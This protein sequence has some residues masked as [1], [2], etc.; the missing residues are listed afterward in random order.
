MKLKRIACLA[1]AVMMM[2]AMAISASAATLNV[3]TD[4]L[5]SS[6]GSTDFGAAYA[7]NVKIV[8]T[9]STV[10]LTVNDDC[11]LDR[12]GAKFDLNNGVAAG[13]KMPY[14]TY[15]VS[16]DDANCID[17]LALALYGHTNQFG[18]G[19]FYQVGV[20]V[21]KDFAP[22]DDGSYDFSAL[23]PVKVYGGTEAAAASDL[24]KPGGTVDLDLTAAVSA[25]GETQDVYV[26]LVL[27][28]T[29]RSGTDYSRFRIFTVELTATQKAATPP[30]TQA[31]ETQA[32]ET[33]AP[34]TQAP[35]T[36]A[37]STSDNTPVP[38]Q[39]DNAILSALALV[40]V[41]GLAVAFVARKKR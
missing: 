20:Y 19:N 31:P 12:Q 4:Y 23:T 38:P 25:L 8:D 6:A 13:I 24:T 36:Q 15:K 35:T 33:Q 9:N 5:A 10:C 16:A 40:L 37:P 18:G 17:T 28:L 2:A 30:A 21:T 7:Y 14:V 22:A 1:L 41:S 3:K 34:A 26:T 27:N 32:P 11:T 29:W 39:G